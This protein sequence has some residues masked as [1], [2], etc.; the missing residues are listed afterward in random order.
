MNTGRRSEGR[1]V[2]RPLIAAMALLCGWVEIS[3]IH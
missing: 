1:G 3:A 2:G